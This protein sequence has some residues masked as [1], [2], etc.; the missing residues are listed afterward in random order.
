MDEERK[1]KDFQGLLLACRPGALGRLCPPR[2][3]SRPLLRGAFTGA[4]G[5]DR[6]LRIV[7]SMKAVV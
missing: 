5:A 4:G 1:G 3:L 7:G 2:R 6:A